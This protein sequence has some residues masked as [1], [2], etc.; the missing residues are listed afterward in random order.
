MLKSFSSRFFI[1]KTC[2]YQTLGKT[3]TKIEGA[4][5][6]KMRKETEVPEE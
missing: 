5:G 3:P 2:N 6:T 4:K 1:I